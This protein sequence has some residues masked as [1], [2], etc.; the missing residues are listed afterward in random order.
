MDPVVS[1]SMQLLNIFM[2]SVPRLSI[3]SWETVFTP[4]HYHF[5]GNVDY[6]TGAVAD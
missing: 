4:S 1:L 2:Q 3:W 5:V 6:V